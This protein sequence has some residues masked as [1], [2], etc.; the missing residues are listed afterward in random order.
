[1]TLTI[2]SAAHEENG[3]LYRWVRLVWNGATGKWWKPAIAQPEAVAAA[4]AM[5]GETT[6]LRMADGG[7]YDLDGKA[8]GLLVAKTLTVLL[9]VPKPGTTI[10]PTATAM[11]SGSSG[12]GG[13]GCSVGFA[14]GLALLLWRP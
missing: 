10:A 11:P 5:A 2:Q 8:D 7:P 14:P 6:V 12:G 13:G 1:M 9:G 3:I 4:I